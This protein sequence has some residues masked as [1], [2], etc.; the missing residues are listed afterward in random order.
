MDNNKVC[1]LNSLP[2]VFWGA[3]V[4]GAVFW[5]L[6]VV[7][8]FYGSMKFTSPAMQ[9]FSTYALIFSVPAFFVWNLLSTLLT[10][11]AAWIY[12]GNKYL[13]LCTFVFLI[14]YI[15]ALC[16]SWAVYLHKIMMS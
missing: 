10:F 14:C 8:A 15:C 11:R 7:L 4:G 12:K 9:D 16:L 1:K 3:L 6:V 5:L 2:W 13:R